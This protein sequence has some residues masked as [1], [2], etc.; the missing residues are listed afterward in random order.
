M[1]FFGHDMHKPS[2]AHGNFPGLESMKRVMR[3]KFRTKFATRLEFMY[4]NY[5]NAYPHGVV[6]SAKNYSNVYPHCVVLATKNYSNVYPHGG[7]PANQN[8]SSV[9]PHSGVP[10]NQNYSSVYPHSGVPAN[11]NYSNVYMHIVLFPRPKIIPMSR[12]PHF[13]HGGQKLFPMNLFGKII[14]RP[15]PHIGII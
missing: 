12:H 1:A 4:Q 8:Y 10:A 14:P 6:L 13:C 15:N 5:P 11:Q 7:V 2:E 3:S 9:Y